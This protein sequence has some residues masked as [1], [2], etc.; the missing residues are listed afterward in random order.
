MKRLIPILILIAFIAGCDLTS[1]DRWN[2]NIVVI[3]GNL[4][5]GGYVDEMHPITIG[6][7]V[8]ADGGSVDDLYADDAEVKLINVTRQDTISLQYNVHFTADQEM[9]IGYIDAG[10]EMQIHYGETY[11]LEALVD[12]MFAYGETT[13]PDEVETNVDVNGNQTLTRGYTT[14]YME[15]LPEIVYDLCDEQFPVEITTSNDETHYV[16]YLHYCLEDFSTEIEYTIQFAGREHLEE[17]DED[18]WDPVIGS[19]MRQNSWTSRYSPVLKDN[20]D[21]SIYDDFYASGFSF[22]G[23]YRF[24]II[25]MDE[26]YYMYKTVPEGFIHGGIHGGVGYFGSSIVNTYYT[27]IVKEYSN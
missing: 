18:Y 16:R 8:E 7:A 4:P 23:R 10:L 2:D 15:P 11:R 22:Y 1:D 5:A 19:G 17:D 24:D 9:K 14:T 13:V 21:Y 25:I 6:R 27:N 20:G 12:S 3:T 26:N